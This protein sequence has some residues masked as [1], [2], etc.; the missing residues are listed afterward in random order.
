MYV[1]PLI[2]TLPTFIPSI[3]HYFNSGLLCLCL[4]LD[5]WVLTLL[6]FYSPIDPWFYDFMLLSGS[7]V[8]VCFL[9]V[10]KG[11]LW[12]TPA[13]MPT[14]L[15]S[16]VGVGVRLM[17]NKALWG[18][19][20]NVQI[21]FD[22]KSLIKKFWQNQHYSNIIKCLSDFG[23]ISHVCSRGNNGSPKLTYSI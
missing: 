3:Y 5:P 17:I 6:F 12:L 9:A 7:N 15:H 18:I 10:G 1:K 2:F 13:G 4:R 21:F 8:H 11:L 14:R 23:G 19:T 22:I 16:T 20:L